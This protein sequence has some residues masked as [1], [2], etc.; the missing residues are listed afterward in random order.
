MTIY[1]IDS[2]I[3]AL[4]DPETG[5][6]LDY[7]A[8]EALTMA[9]DEKLENMALWYKELKATATAIRAE[10]LSL[11][12]RRRAAER[13]AEKLKSYLSELTGGEKF[14]TPRVQVSWRK[15]TSLQLEDGFVD[16]AKYN[17]AWLL[18]NREPEPDKTMIR[19]ALQS[20]QKVYGAELKE[21]YSLQVK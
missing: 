21:S 2:A 1:E 14:S 10:E 20:G 8:F 6:I 13:K 16:W 4:T 11:S 15:S 17:A 19:Q 5:E 12:E 9:R 18:R 3:L 7:D